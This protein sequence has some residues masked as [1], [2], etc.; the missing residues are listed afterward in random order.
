MVI[1]IKSYHKIPNVI[2]YV[3]QKQNA[4]LSSWSWLPLLS[5]AVF[6]IVF[7]LG[8]GPIPWIIMGE[9][10]PNNVKVSRI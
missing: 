6:I 2:L 1:N 7:S 9:L 4:D 10:V 5:L 8:Y 3:F